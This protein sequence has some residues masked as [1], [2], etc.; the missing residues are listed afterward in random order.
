[1]QF[2][3]GCLCSFVKQV[4]LK[5][6]VQVRMQR[7]MYVNCE[8]A[9]ADPT[10]ELRQ[11]RHSSSRTRRDVR[12]SSCTNPSSPSCST[13]PSPSCSSPSFPFDSSPSS[14]PPAPSL[15]PPPPTP[16]LLPPPSHSLQC[17]SCQICF[18]PV[19][20]KSKFE[21]LV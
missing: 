2:W 16:S 12:G 15:L 18:D 10:I 6:L 11:T 4:E 20:M 17:S 8:G 7:C 14:S 3:C 1:M 9:G 13:P 19:V 5:V 21:S